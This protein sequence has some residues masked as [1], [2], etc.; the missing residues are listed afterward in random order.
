DDKLLS[1]L[2]T[3]DILRVRR[4]NKAC[5]GRVR[6]YYARAFNVSHALR[7]FL[8]RKAYAAFQGM[9]AQTGL[10]ISGRVA[11]DFIR[12]DLCLEDTMDTFV[13]R[14]S[15]LDVASTLE[16][17]DY[18]YV[19]DVLPLRTIA[20]AVDYKADSSTFNSSVVGVHVFRHS[21]GKRIVVHV[22]RTS[23]VDCILGYGT[24]ALM[25]FVSHTSA[26]ALY[27]K[28]TLIDRRALFLA[29]PP[30]MGVPDDHHS[31]RAYGY[32]NTAQV[33]RLTASRAAHEWGRKFRYV[34]DDLTCKI[35]LSSATYVD[36][37]HW[38]YLLTR[39]QRHLGQRHAPIMEALLS[40]H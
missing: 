14:R 11:L 15:V 1:Y 7:S 18:R 27:P 39:L 26:Y 6:Q 8:P 2:D 30:W 29:P 9:Q 21:S 22:A 5:E 19:P 4:I 12:R 35:S 13:N 37:D 40:S 34:G 33:T 31:K 10:L 32:K 16:N 20:E 36:L 3:A 38:R 25:N 28:G 17:L 24:S 23:T